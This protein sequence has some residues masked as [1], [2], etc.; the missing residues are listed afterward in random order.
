[1][2]RRLW[3]VAALAALLLAVTPF[4]G[5]VAVDPRA[6]L[7]P[8]PASFIFWQLRLPRALLG[9]AAGGILA[10]AG[11]VCQNLFRNDLA[12]PDLLGVSSGAAAGAVIA[13]QLQGGMA[14]LGL[15]GPALFS[16][17]GALAAVLLIF[18][19]ARLVRSFSLYTLLM[20]GVAINLFFSAV[21]VI[22]QY[23]LDFADT[24]SLLRWLTGGIVVAGYFEAVFLLALLAA[25]LAL[26]W[27]FRRELLLV[28]AGDDFAESRGLDAAAFR[29]WA[30]IALAV[31]VGAVVSLCGPI[32]FVALVVPHLGRAWGRCRHGE[33]VAFTVLLGGGLLVLADLLAR[34]LLPPVEVPVGVVTA[35][36]GAP[37]FLFL[38]LAQLRRGE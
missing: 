17:M 9:F 30:F 25:F 28:S 8:S 24:F 19:I 38:L 2:S 22:F 37:F 15:G 21:I 12:T 34:S 36:L 32:G 10:L 31:F 7:R 13:L 20:S 1:M 29:R 23:V 11:W 5:V 4:L 27:I 33:T 14:G 6:L 16:F 35:L 26:A 3:L 18:A